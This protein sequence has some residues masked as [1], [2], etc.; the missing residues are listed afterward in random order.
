[1]ANIDCN[2]VPVKDYDANNLDNLDNEEIDQAEGA[3]VQGDNPQL[4][5]VL[6]REAQLV[7]VLQGEEEGPHLAGDVPREA[8]ESDA[9]S[10]TICPPR[11]TS[12]FSSVDVFSW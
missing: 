3:N 1:M 10:N 7:N 11:P 8:S 5:N 12:V 2:N 6:Q 9:F 4:V